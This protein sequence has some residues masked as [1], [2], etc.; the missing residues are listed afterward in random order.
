[1]P[2]TSNNIRLGSVVLTSNAN[3]FITISAGGLKVDNQK[4]YAI[5]ANTPIA[6]LL[7]G[8]QQGDRFK[9]RDQ[10]FEIIEVL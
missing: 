3:Y 9:F 4:F 1:L 5:S 6:K 2:Q 7:L 8:K 10:E